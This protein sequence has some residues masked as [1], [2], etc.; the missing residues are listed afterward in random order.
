MIYASIL[1][2]LS[3]FWRLSATLFCLSSLWD[4]VCLSCFRSSI[5]SIQIVKS[6]SIQYRSINDFGV[7]NV[8]DPETWVFQRLKYSHMC[9]F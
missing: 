1:F 4:V 9:M 3:W 7:V 8:A 2:F 5:C 6:T